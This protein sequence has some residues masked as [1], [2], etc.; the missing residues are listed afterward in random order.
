MC[1]IFSSIYL[2]IQGFSCCFQCV[3]YKIDNIYMKKIYKK[4]VNIV[5]YKTYNMSNNLYKI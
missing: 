4:Y 1:L 5:N 2:E 3:K